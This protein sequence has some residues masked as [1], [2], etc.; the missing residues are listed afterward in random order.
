[1]AERASLCANQYKSSKLRYCWGKAS[2]WETVMSDKIIP[3]ESHRQATDTP[4]APKTRPPVPR[5]PD[6]A[7]ADTAWLQP[8]DIAFLLDAGGRPAED[9][10]LIAQEASPALEA[11]LEQESVYERVAG[12]SGG[13]IN[14]SPQLYFHVMLRR[15]LPRP[16]D[17]L[18]R[19]VIRYLANLLSLFVRTERLYQI[20]P[21]ESASFEYLVDLLTEAAES[22]H[23]RQ[24]LVHAH[25]GNY[26]LYLSGMGRAWIEYR[27]KF[28]RSSLGLGYYRDMGR[29]AYHQ[30]AVHRL[31][32]DL[33]LQ[34]V[35]EYLSQQ[36]EAYASALCQI[37]SGRLYPV[38]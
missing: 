29:R 14:I 4:A 15:L 35:F 3:F 27:L 19:R 30:A 5:V 2:A 18:Q 20:Q 31:A 28:G 9:A 32:D 7:H 17:Y 26:A 11:L 13:W 10:Q 1:M 38:Q 34:S 23:E 21:G 24:F 16:Q 37:G 25:L 6:F 12:E 8:R 36:F 22:E 33:G